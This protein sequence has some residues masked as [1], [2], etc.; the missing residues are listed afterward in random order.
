MPASPEPEDLAGLER[1]ADYRFGTLIKGRRYAFARGLTINPTHLPAALDAMED[2][3][4]ELV[5]IFG[6]TDAENIGFI[7]KRV[8]Q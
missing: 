2:D 6:K 7:F 4:F 1:L 8:P 5:A 3:G